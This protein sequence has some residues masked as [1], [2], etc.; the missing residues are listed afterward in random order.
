MQNLAFPKATSYEKTTDNYRTPKINP[1]FG[2]ILS[3]WSEI[4]KKR[5]G[6]KANKANISPLVQP[7][8]RVSNLEFA[9]LFPI[10]AFR[11]TLNK[12]VFTVR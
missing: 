2:L 8:G 1:L 10:I 5:K 11:Q 12:Q 7:I 6:T 9:D 3:L 4:E